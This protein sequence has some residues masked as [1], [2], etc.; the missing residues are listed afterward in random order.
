MDGTGA[1]VIPGTTAFRERLDAV[2]AETASAKALPNLCYV[3]ADFLQYERARLFEAG[4]ACIGFGKDVPQPGDVVPRSLLGLPLILLRDSARNIRVFHNV[5]SHR[6][7]EL[8]AEPCHVTGVLRCPYHSWAYDLE[9][10]L[11]ATPFIGG[12]GVSRCEGFDKAAHGLKPVRT[13]VWFDLVFVNLDGKAVEFSSYIGPVAERWSMFDGS[14]IRH[15]GADS[16]AVFDVHCNWKL[17]VENYCEAYHLPWVHPG[18]NSYSRLEDHYNINEWDSFAG[19]GSRV[20]RPSLTDSGEELPNF[21]DLPRQFRGGAEYAALFPNVLLGVHQDHFMAVRLEPIAVDR[22]LEHLELYYVGEAALGDTYAPIRSA[23][24]R[25]WKQVFAEDVG[26][27]ERMQRGRA[28]PAFDGGVFSPV[29]DVP[30][31]CFHK[32]AAQRLM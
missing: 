12:P 26:V 18:L 31:H 32:W 20:Y 3:D 4:W 23:N 29:M 15:S 14:L 7:A 13:A 9:G 10:R 16:S 21:P 24:L 28:S 1:E 27:V 8:V 2:L 11:K 19:Q 30:T 6:G 22:T 25:T 5:C 17:A